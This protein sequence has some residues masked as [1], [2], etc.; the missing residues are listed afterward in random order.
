MNRS[1]GRSAK[2][3]QKTRPILVLAVLV[4]ATA[5][6]CTTAAPPPPPNCEPETPCPTDPEPSDR[7]V[8]LVDENGRVDKP[9]VGLAPGRTVVDGKGTGNVAE[10]KVMIVKG[11]PAGPVNPVCAGAECTLTRAAQ[12][13]ARGRFR[14]AVWVERSDGSEAGTDPVLIINP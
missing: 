2:G 5:T 10:L 12:R 1:A 7:V 11:P 4:L 9:C 14:Y 13:P 6:A 3:K 8:I